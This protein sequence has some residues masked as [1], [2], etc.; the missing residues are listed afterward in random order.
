M[1][2]SSKRGRRS[3]ADATRP[4]AETSYLVVSPKELTCLEHVDS[5]AADFVE[6]Y[7]DRAPLLL[8]PENE[9]GVRKFVCTTVC[10]TKLPFPSVHDAKACGKFM[11]Q[12]IDTELLEHPASLPSYLPSPTFVLQSFRGD[13]FDVSTLLCSFLTGAGYDAYVV[14]GYAPLATC[15]ADTSNCDAPADLV[16]LKPLLDG[17]AAQAKHAEKGGGSKREKELEVQRAADLDRAVLGVDNPMRKS[18]EDEGPATWQ[19]A[20]PISAPP[21]LES[22]FRKER[23]Q[24][25]LD[26]VKAASILRTASI[27]VSLDQ[28]ESD[29]EFTTACARPAV[30]TAS[31]EAKIAETAA[32]AEA[33]DGAAAVRAA[34]HAWVLVVAGRNDVESHF[35]V[36]SI[37]GRCYP[38]GE[39][40]AAFG[41][42]ESVWSHKNVWVNLQGAELSV[43][44]MQF[45]LT[46]SDAW[47]PVVPDKAGDSDELDMMDGGHRGS[48]VGGLTPRSNHGSPRHKPSSTR[49]GTQSPRV[50]GPGSPR[51]VRRQMTGRGLVPAGSPRAQSLSGPSSEI[52]DADGE[53][54]PTIEMP[55]SWVKD[56]AVAE[57]VFRHGMPAHKEEETRLYKKVRVETFAPGARTDCMRMSVTRYRDTA[58]STKLHV[59]ERFESRADNLIRRVLFWGQVSSLYSPLHFVRILLTI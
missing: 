40:S 49:R 45:D 35:F 2:V 5:F 15:H 32:A 33:E 23:E 50:G 53:E 36:D 47:L 37:S 51:G 46:Q 14:S 54:A 22:D 44:E 6:K 30:L 31:V 27:V 13:S 57:T 56:L 25:K 12:L 41:A 26:A 48:V 11:A 42:I 20:Y 8:T 10:P 39:A 38:V 24:E 7:P 55:P 4:Q 58:R 29:D 52:G 28:E 34:V 21:K 18:V 3:A 17:F 19:E 16:S 43:D 59:I 9:F 1:R